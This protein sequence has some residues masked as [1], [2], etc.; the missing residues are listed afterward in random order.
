MFV[1]RDSFAIAF[2]LFIR[3]RDGA[4]GEN[5]A[6]SDPHVMKGKMPYHKILCRN[7]AS[8]GA[9]ELRLPPLHCNYSVAR[10]LHTGSKYSCSV[11][12]IYLSLLHKMQRSDIHSSMT[13]SVTFFLLA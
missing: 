12:S 2:L 13:L 4:G 1:L 3:V 8:D 6:H 9:K 5:A 7:G 11:D 10:L